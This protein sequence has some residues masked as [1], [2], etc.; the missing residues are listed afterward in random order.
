MTDFKRKNIIVEKTAEKLDIP[1][2]KVTQVLSAFFELVID[3]IESKNYRGA[4]LR[5][6][7]KFVVKPNRVK[8]L[9]ERKNG[10]KI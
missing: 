7:G 10:D 9:E 1:E 6:L 4:Y 8:M 3:D 2:Y 5:R